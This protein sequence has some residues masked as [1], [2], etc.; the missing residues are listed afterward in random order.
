MNGCSTMT[1]IYHGVQSYFEQWSGHLV[2]I[3]YR[4]RSILFY[5]SHLKI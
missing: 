3:H 4:N 5:T 1:G 2:Y